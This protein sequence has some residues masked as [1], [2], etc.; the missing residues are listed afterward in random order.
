MDTNTSKGRASI[1]IPILVLVVTLIVRI[2]SF[3]DAYQ[4]LQPILR[5]IVLG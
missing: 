3:D 2:E 5:S 4:E 1:G